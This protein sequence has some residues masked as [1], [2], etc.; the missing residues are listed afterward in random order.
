MFGFCE[1]CILAKQAKIFYKN[2]EKIISDRMQWLALK[3]TTATAFG[4]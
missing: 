3:N 1:C 4:R 2:L